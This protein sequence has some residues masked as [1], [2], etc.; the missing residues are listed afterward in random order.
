MTIL[1]S[2]QDSGGRSKAQSIAGSGAGFI[3]VAANI[4]RL[5]LNSN[6]TARL[7]NDSV[8]RRAGGLTIQATEQADLDVDGSGFAAGAVGGA[9]ALILD[10][11]IDAN[12][13]AN[14]GD[15]VTL[16]AA[17]E[18]L[19]YVTIDATS[20]TVAKVDGVLLAAGVLGADFAHLKADVGV[21]TEA[22]IG[23]TD[24]IVTDD[25]ELHATANQV[26]HTDIDGASDGLLSVGVL[27]ADSVISGTTR[28]EVLPTATLSSDG[29]IDIFA[30][31][32]V[33]GSSDV[34][35][36]SVGLLAV[37]GSLSKT[38]I[39]PNV[40]A[41]AGGSI[42]AAN[43]SVS[44][45]LSYP[46]GGYSAQA[47]AWASAGSLVGVTGSD[48]R[49]HVG[50]QVNS[51]I[52]DNSILRVADSLMISAVGDTKQR[53]DASGVTIGGI[54]A[55]GFNDAEASSNV[56]T[57]AYLG[58]NID[59][60]GSEAIGGLVDGENYYILFIDELFFNAATAVNTSTDTIFLGANHG[61][62]TGDEIVY[63]T[64]FGDTLITTSDPNV[65]GLNDGQIYYAIYDPSSPETIR[66]ALTEERAYN[67]NS[68]DITGIGSGTQRF[69][70][71]ILE[72]R[73][74]QAHFMTI[75]KSSSWSIWTRVLRAVANT[76]SPQ[77]CLADF[78]KLNLI[79]VLLLITDSTGLFFQLVMVSSMNRS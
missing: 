66:L 39:T 44:A 10:A 31:Q 3:A 57:Q 27:S 73:D 71:E 6:T 21:N 45:L 68:V 72:L 35:G 70:I 38:E 33:S 4:S 56:T 41:S 1:A 2:D 59:I 55:L 32:L 19:G 20:D 26:A 60:A 14:I 15:R 22:F 16:G 67:G 42:T 36:V 28:A 51:F 76:V 12:V 18:P 50:G 30:K 47:D 63:L 9:G 75:R 54:V 23:D 13:Y 49:A 77:P 74:W 11:D 58:N 7:K 53:A 61:L 52:A 62:Q 5:E 34:T 48:S 37:E 43:L 69:G 46:N 29:K 24:V 78:P 64:D 40:I 65:T 8:V 25:L 17:A 79:R